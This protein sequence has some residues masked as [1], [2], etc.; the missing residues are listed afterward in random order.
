M[1]RI[2]SKNT[3]PTAAGLIQPLLLLT[4]VLGATTTQAAVQFCTEPKCGSSNYGDPGTKRELLLSD[5]RFRREAGSRSPLEQRYFEVS[6]GAKGNQSMISGE[7]LFGDLA[8]QW[9]SVNAFV[10]VPFSDSGAVDDQLLVRG[11]PTQMLPGGDRYEAE[12]WTRSAYWF[13]IGNGIPRLLSSAL[14]DPTYVPEPG[15]PFTDSG[16]LNFSELVL[17]QEEGRD[18][19][20]YPED[21]AFGSLFF[22]ADPQTGE[23]LDI[24]IALNDADGAFE[25]VAPLFVG[26]RLKPLVITY[27]LA[28]P[29]FLYYSEYGD[30]ITL[31]DDVD[32]GLANHV[33]GVDFFDPDLFAAGFD[34]N[35]A[36]LNLL[37][38]GYREGMGGNDEW[39]YS[40]VQ[41]LGYTWG[42][43]LDQFFASGFELGPNVA[44]KRA[45][46]IHER[47]R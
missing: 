5:A 27:R 14:I 12:G 41:P 45:P 9:D 3:K 34:A 2:R 7:S 8:G 21:G 38:E 17:Y 6:P 28:E 23:V 15:D 30:Y 22:V 4:C 13:D 33:P 36:S 39:A 16:H 46:L 32:I 42:E 40:A 35:S 20:A 29:E 26:D 44:A 43:A 19:S 37:L 31:N 25:K 1:S 24:V 10:T 47:D 11:L 18:Y